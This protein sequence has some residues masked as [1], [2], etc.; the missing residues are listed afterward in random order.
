MKKIIQLIYFS[1][2][3]LALVAQET[4]PFTSSISGYV[5]ND[6]FYDTRETVSVRDGHFLLWPSPVAL[7]SVNTDIN[8]RAQLNMLAIQSRLTFRFSGSDVLGARTSG[9]IEGDFFGNASINS[10]RLRHA[11]V[12]LKWEHT[13]LISGQYW[14]PLFVTSCFPGTI[15]FNTGTPFNSFARNPQLRIT[16]T[17]GSMSFSGALLSQV[18]NVSRGSYNSKSS[19]HL[20]QSVIPDAHLQFSYAT[21][22]DSTQR[23]FT[24]GGGIAYK[25][26]RPRN[27]SVVDNKI[28]TVDESVHGLTAIAFSKIQTSLLTIKLSMRYGENIPD[29]TAP[30]GFAVQNISDTITGKSEYTPLTSLSYWGEIHT[31]GNHWEFGLFGGFFANTGTKETMSRATNPVYGLA[32]NITRLYRISPRIMYTINKFRVGL[33]YE[34]TGAVYGEKF[35]A[36]YKAHS[37]SNDVSNSRILF[38]TVYSF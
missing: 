25:Q 31:N 10:L 23:A 15:S 12:K 9:L 22:N 5:K 28:Y 2:I 26:I 7:D 18:D 24:C 8:N 13:E 34:Y 38:T 6:V 27:T 37:L 20:R 16:H 36:N 4:K 30:G 14:N 3:S 33:E 1:T 17:L 11:F 29:I 19:S 35:D 32:T 21:K